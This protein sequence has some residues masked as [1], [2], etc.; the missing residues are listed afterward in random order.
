MED[1]GGLAG[2][3]VNAS[4]SVPLEIVVQNQ[5]RPCPLIVDPVVGITGEVVHKE[6]GGDRS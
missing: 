1:G 5:G 6:A 3:Q 4:V 2:R